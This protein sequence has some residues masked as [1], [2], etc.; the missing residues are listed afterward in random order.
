METE[1]KVL[2]ALQQL[3]EDINE[4]TA[5]PLSEQRTWHSKYYVNSAQV[6]RYTFRATPRAVRS[7]PFLDQLATVENIERNRR[8]AGRHNLSG[9]L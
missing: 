1:E 5:P 9:A 8:R 6:Q 3:H 7:S 2:A 4:L